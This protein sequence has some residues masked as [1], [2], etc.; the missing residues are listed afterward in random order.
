MMSKKR[1]LT[2]GA[3]SVAVA[4]VMTVSLGTAAHAASYDFGSKTCSWP[5]RAAIYID[6]KGS[7]QLEQ[8]WNNGD[9]YHEQGW[10]NASSGTPR[11]KVVPVGVAKM[12]SGKGKYDSSLQQAGKDCR[13]L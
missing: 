1:K 10:Y 6:A 9:S 3:I 8:W 5:G 2:V 7:I 13:L 11:V 4:A 12:S